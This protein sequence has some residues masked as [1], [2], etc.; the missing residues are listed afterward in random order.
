MPGPGTDAGALSAGDG[1]LQHQRAHLAWLRRLRTRHPRRGLGELRLRGD[2]RRLR[3]A[4]GADLQST[5]DQEDFRL[6]PPIA[7]GAPLQVLPEQ[8]GNWAYPQA[9]MSAEEIA[10]TQVTGLAGRLYQSGRLD[11]LDA[12]QRDLVHAATAL[13]RDDLRHHLVRAVPA[14]PLGH[15][16]WDGDA[17]ALVLEAPGGAGAGPAACSSSGTGAVPAR[18]WCWRSPASGPPTCA[19]STRAGSSRGASRTPTVAWSCAPVERGRGPGSTTWAEGVFPDAR[20]F[21]VTELG[22]G[23][24]AGQGP[25]HF[26]W[27]NR[28][29]SAAVVGTVGDGPAGRGRRPRR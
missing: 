24:G 20:G 2:A 26:G 8:G 15:A 4:G 23:V 19:S 27:P 17:V 1:L 7:A 14:W 25:D 10:F 16:R 6:Y 5:S 9:W 13:W 28:S 21:R 29:T 12:E 11:L 18:R 22:D 3:D